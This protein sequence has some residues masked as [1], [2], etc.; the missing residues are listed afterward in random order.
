MPNFR[1]E[2]FAFVSGTF[3][4]FR[5]AKP[6]TVPLWLAVYLKER[7]KCQVQPPRWFDY[8]YLCKVKAVE[9]EL[10][11]M[12]SEE[13]PYYYFEVANLLLNNCADEFQ[14]VQK[15]KSVIE[16]IFELRREKLVR[17]LKNVEPQTPVKFLSNVG[18][19]ELNSIRPAFT[20]AFTVAGHMQN[21]LEN[22]QRAIETNAAQANNE[23]L[24]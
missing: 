1:E 20:A 10:G 6:V 7:N 8:E 22:C 14:S 16:D 17:M 5:P 4:P 2:A 12:F 11:D 21:I 3:G 15:M 24:E 9:K 23:G 19:V 13:I 18:A